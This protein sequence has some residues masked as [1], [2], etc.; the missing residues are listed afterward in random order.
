MRTIYALVL[1]TLGLV[2]AGCFS[3]GEAPSPPP[4]TGS[5][6]LQENFGI[7]VGAIDTSPDFR[8]GFA[9]TMGIMPYPNDILGFLANGTNDGTLNL[10]SVPFQPLVSVVNRLDGFSTFGRI[11]ANFFD[12]QIAASSLSTPGAV[13]LLEVVLDPATKAT[14]GVVGPLIPG[15]DYTVSVADD[16]DAGGRMLEINPL[17]PLN[18]KSGYL[19]ILTNAIRDTA[20]NAAKPDATYQ[21]IKNAIAAGVTLPDPTQDLLKQF[22]GAHLA[23]AGAIGIPSA[24][25]IV[26]ASFSTVSIT[27][28]LDYINDTATA[29]FS[30]IEQVFAP[31]DITTPSGTLP[32]GSPITTG[33]VLSLQGAASQCAPTMAFPLPGCGLVFAGA[34]GLP[35]YLEVPAD[36]NDAAAVTSFWQGTPGVNPLDATSTNLSR[37]NP[38]PQKKADVLVPSIM[39]VP[40]PNSAYVQAGGMKPAE[41]WPV[42]I[43]IHGVTRNRLDMFAIAESFNNAGVAVIAIDQ[44]LHG[45]TATDPATDPTALFRVPGVSER[46]FDLD[47]VDNTTNTGAPDGL[48]DG[49][50]IHFLNPGTDRLLPT[51]DHFRQSAADVIHLVRTIATIDIDG[52]TIPDLD[53][54][55]LHYVGQ[56]LGG[57][58]GNLVTGVNGDFA[59]ATLGVTGG[60]L[61]CGLFESPTFAATLGA[62]LAAGL[63]ASGILKDSTAFDNYLRDAQNI[64]DAG[65]ALNYALAWSNDQL[66]PVHQIKVIGDTVVPNSMNDRIALAMGLPQ[67]PTAQ[68]P[69]FPFPVF[70][71]PDTGGVNGGLVTFTAGAHGSQLDPTASPAATVEMQTQQVVFAVGNPPAMIPGNGQVILISDPTVVDTDGP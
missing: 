27:D 50:G 66:T 57:L 12:G 7:D 31:F 65:D 68:P 45:V 33:I 52:D 20:G 24:N 34:V 14:V 1:T 22:V 63:Q 28:A 44:V 26:T 18:P 60:C 46:T 19:L 32:Q 40:G 42:V 51:A 48:I 35:Y 64:V 58:T 59:S 10:T 67:V 2:L 39:A 38:V 43:Y 70:V 23:I 30:S 8:A 3:E 25:V 56:S 36:Q 11:T 55:R 37:F 6:G 61:S 17:K 4:Q 47:L 13:T 69:G 21:D 16:I 71:G 29:Q 5:T 15:V 62:G 41:G 9:P 53:G 49:S 54:S